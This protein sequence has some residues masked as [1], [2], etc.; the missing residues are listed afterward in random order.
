MK[1]YLF[2]KELEEDKREGFDNIL[3]NWVSS[4][5]QHI[6][7]KDNLINEHFLENN[8]MFEIYGI[9]ENNSNI[10]L[11][12]DGL[13]VH[14]LQNTKKGGEIIGYSGT[15]KV[16]TVLR[17]SDFTRYLKNNYSEKFIPDELG[18]SV[19]EMIDAF[20]D[21][22]CSDVSSILSKY[23]D[24]I[25]KPE[26]RI[27][28]STWNKQNETYNPFEFMKTE[29]AEEA[30]TAL[31][32]GFSEYSNE[33]LLAF[34]FEINPS[35]LYRPTICDSVYNDYFRPTPIST[36]EYG[37]IKCLNNGE[38][39]IV[40]KVKCISEMGKFLPEAVTSGSNFI[41]KNLLNCKLLI[42]I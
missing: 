17:K 20:I 23:N 18:K 28:W 16:G 15:M 4:K 1:N 5:P 10:D 14:G 2:Y 27:I 41:I 6:Q 3:K 26:N 24:I 21:D 22:L 12:L 37:I 9:I 11:L 38:Y 19:D 13:I 33:K 42:T 7:K 39:T 30:I 29:Y 34:V 40:D 8:V 32:L 25:I 36:K 35:L 31:G